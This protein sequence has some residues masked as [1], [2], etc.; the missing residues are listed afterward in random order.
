[1]WVR[2]AFET[3]KQSNINNTY[4]L[5]YS[6]LYESSTKSFVKIMLIFGG[7]LFLDIIYYLSQ[8]LETIGTYCIDVVYY[9]IFLSAYSVSETY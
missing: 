5:I 6:G 4:I 1:M 2:F 8:E 7:T 9:W 3:N